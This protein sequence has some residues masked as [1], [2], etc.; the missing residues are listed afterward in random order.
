METRG[1][2]QKILKFLLKEF[3][4]KPTITI[5]AK[6]IGMS[7]VGMWKALK[8]MQSEKLIMLLSI[9]A[10]KTSTYSISLNWDNVLTG[11]KLELILTEDAVKNQRWLNN[12][13]ELEE[14]V[15]FLIIYGSV[16]N[17]LKEANDIDIL[18]VVSNKNKF[19]EIE[20]SIAKIQKTQIKK[21]HDLNFTQTEFKQEIEKP[22]N[23]FIDAVRKGVIIFGQDKFLKFMRGISK[24]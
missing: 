1:S 9:G 15:D 12:F 24:K 17:S 6:E 21:I 22:N 19:I 3:S 16:L 13:A 2:S 14:K 20:K 10:G 5:L 7:R 23:A 18:G 4:I 11:K 8:R